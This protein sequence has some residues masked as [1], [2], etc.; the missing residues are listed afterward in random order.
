MPR[1]RCRLAIGL[2]LSV[3]LLGCSAPTL[4]NDW[5]RYTGPGAE[6]FQKEEITLPFVPDPL[7]VPNRIVWAA[8]ELILFGIV[9]PLAAV[10]RFLVPQVVRD[11]LV[12]AVK[13]LGY[14]VRVVHDLLEGD[15]DEANVETRRFL[16]NST[17]GIAGLVDRA[18]EMGIEPPEDRD[19]GRMLADSGWR[20]ST[21]LTLPLLG[22][23]TTRDALGQ[24][25]DAAV[26]PATY[27]FPAALIMNFVAGAERIDDFERFVRTSLDA[28]EPVKRIW[29]IDRNFAPVESSNGDE[30]T[31]A[32]D[33]LRSLT[34]TFEDPWFASRAQ[35]LSVKLPT[36]G[37][38]M[39]YELW[40][41]PEPAPIVFIVP[42]LGSH[43]LSNMSIA[44]AE[45]VYR[46]GFSAVTVSSAMNFDFMET[47]STAW[48]PGFAPVDAGDLHV[49]LDAVFRDLERRYP[50]RTTQRVL[51][52]LSLG[53]FHTL[54][55][56]ASESDS[57]SGLIDF[58]R[59][60]AVNPPVTMSSCVNRL[61][62]F[63]NA[64]LV[65][66][67]EVRDE[68]VVGVLQKAVRLALQGNVEDEDALSFSRVEADFLIGLN[69][70]VALH[71]VIWSSQSRHNM[72]ILK[73]PLR[74]LQRA[75]STEE[76]LDFS[77][78]E[79]FYAFVFPYFQNRDSEIT[80]PEKMF[81]LMDLRFIADS[82]PGSGKV[83]I[84]SNWDDFV[85]TPEQIR[86]LMEV[87]GEAN[88]ICQPEGGHMGA[89][90]DPATREQ[91]MDSLEDLLPNAVQSSASTGVTG[92]TQVSPRRCR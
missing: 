92:L 32:V 24:L 14:P 19:L 88:V 87:F 91:M 90:F 69:F 75:A 3:G 79:Y 21:Y 25:G 82:L 41:Q 38:R 43:R 78:V 35:S 4:R 58:D 17:I 10:W 22:P 68:R 31:G 23:S 7:E 56:A 71:D 66:P 70:R 53:G 36:T 30:E 34:F 52:G 26:D 51:M 48:V 37:K 46:R 85:V 6:H 8:N 49:A 64:P 76:I 44:T 42:G 72:G 80:S 40:L 83:R 18:A 11:H 74:T 57:T 13:N 33:E 54:Y 5:S 9:S 65:Y 27:F 16:I 84:Y 73:T 89:L 67:P 1:T 60:V 63:Y 77:Y 15:F 50:D 28:Y 47:A 45:M 61:D 81:E 12:N 55:I 29:T 62:A 39:R 20:D 86:W 59:Y 2:L